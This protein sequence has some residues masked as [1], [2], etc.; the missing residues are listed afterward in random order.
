MHCLYFK[1]TTLTWLL[2]RL[3]ELSLISYRFVFQ[4]VA[5][6]QAQLEQRRKDAEQRD[7]L[8]QSLSQ[9]TE[10]LKNKLTTVSARCQ[11]LETQVTVSWPTL[12]LSKKFP[13]PNNL[14]SAI[15]NLYF[16]NDVVGFKKESDYWLTP[17]AGTVWSVNCCIT[18]WIFTKT[19]KEWEEIQIITETLRRHFFHLLLFC[20]SCCQKSLNRAAWVVISLTLTAHFPVAWD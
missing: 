13:L 2:R 17:F 8:F 14:L 1:E 10:N 7:M 20:R 19:V 6:L 15:G 16:S 9:E 11:S 3:V 4:V 12:Y 18:A 5:S